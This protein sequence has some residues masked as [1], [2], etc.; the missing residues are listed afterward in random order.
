[1]RG[2]VIEAAHYV[3]ERGFS[4]PRRAEEHDELAGIEVKVNATEGV[5]LRLAHPVDLGKPLYAEDRLSV[6]GM[7]I[8]L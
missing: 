7:V 6:H 4:A 8:I 1:M 2:D 5:Y 3:E